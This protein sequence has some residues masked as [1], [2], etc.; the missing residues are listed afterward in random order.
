MRN[1][2]IAA[3][4]LLLASQTAFAESR[5]GHVDIYYVPSADF[6]IDIP[7]FGSGSDDGDGFGFKGLIP[8]D[9]LAITAGYQSVG[10]DESGIDFDQL[11][12][13]VG[14]VGPTTSGVFVEYIDAD[15]ADA[16]ADGFGIQGRLAGEQFYAQ[17][18][19]V[20][21]DDDSEKIAGPEFLFGIAI[22]GDES[23][24][25]FIDLR[26]TMLEG[27]ESNVEYEFTDVRIGLRIKF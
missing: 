1:R 8:A 27:D 12:I 7:G 9:N 3:T 2:V 16:P 4:A 25:G 11:R 13:G 10:Y 17:V 20:T 18:G 23:V 24:G 15:L 26:K 5:G 21:L 6:E 19:Y 14:M 22:G